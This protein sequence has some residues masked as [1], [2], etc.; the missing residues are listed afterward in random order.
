MVYK[1]DPKYWNG[2]IFTLSDWDMADGFMEYWRENKPIPAAYFPQSLTVDD[3]EQVLPDIFHTARDLVVFSERAR[4]LMEER[5][6]SQVEFIPVT[7]HAEPE[8]VG[9]LQLANSYY[10]INVLGEAQRFQWPQM[11]V[12]AGAVREDGVQIFSAK[13]D[14]ALWKI[15]QR[16]S[17]EPLIWRETWWLSGSK[18]YRGH[19]DVLIE[20]VLWQELNTRFPNQLNSLRVGSSIN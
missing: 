20:D 13:F 3:A 17:G 4:V 12:D 2:T 16:A 7:I 18:E 14:R 5:A 1:F 6:P 15:R 8:V 19:V 11:P 10:F 9:R